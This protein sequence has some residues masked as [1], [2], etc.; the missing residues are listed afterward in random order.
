[1]PRKSNPTS[2]AVSYRVVFVLVILVILGLIILI[3]NPHGSSSTDTGTGTVKGAS[4][5]ISKVKNPTLSKII[6]TADLDYGQSPTTIKTASPQPA[7]SNSLA[8]NNSQ[9]NLQNAASSSSQPSQAE[10]E[11]LINGISPNIIS[12]S[13]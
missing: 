10:T 2:Q 3:V 11:D 1:M 9:T 5:A 7:V 13:N 8:P 4:A 12:P 6:K